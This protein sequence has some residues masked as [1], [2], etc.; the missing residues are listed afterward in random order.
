V[1]GA[2]IP[3]AI[4][5]LVESASYQIALLL[6]VLCYLYIAFYGFVGSKPART[7]TA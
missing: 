5:Y 1:G 6:P 3:V 2:V 7:V 4:G